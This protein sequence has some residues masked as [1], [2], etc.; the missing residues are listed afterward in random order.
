MGSSTDRLQTLKLLL[1]MTAGWVHRDQS[2]PFAYL[3]EKIGVLRAHLGEQ[4]LRFTD[5][6]RVRLGKKGKVLGHGSEEAGK[7]NM[8]LYADQTGI[9]EV[10]GRTK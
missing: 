4:R 9:G 6:Q 3:V 1:T 10:T 5:E 2:T 8:G 7:S